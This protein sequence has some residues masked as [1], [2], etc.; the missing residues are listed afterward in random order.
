MTAID[1]IKVS[2][3]VGAFPYD[4]QGAEIINVGELWNLDDFIAKY[5][6]TDPALLQLALIVRAPTQRGSI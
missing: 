4:I 5:R 1:V 2:Q 6:L 3:E